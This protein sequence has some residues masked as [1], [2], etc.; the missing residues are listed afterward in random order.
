MSE[1]GAC[2]VFG[3][4]MWAFGFV[5]GTLTGETRI[6]KEWNESRRQAPTAPPLEA[7]PDQRQQP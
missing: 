5:I 4:G 7:K 1:V 3:L 2:L 6:L